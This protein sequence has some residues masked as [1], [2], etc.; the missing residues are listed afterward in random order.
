MGGGSWQISRPADASLQGSGCSLF[1]TATTRS[2]RQ[3][4][5]LPKTAG[6]EIIA[7]LDVAE[8][9]FDVVGSA[10]ATGADC[11]LLALREIVRC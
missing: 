8:R 10:G 5:L 11:L 1:M 7:D 3:G 6:P 4:R 9:L 2:H